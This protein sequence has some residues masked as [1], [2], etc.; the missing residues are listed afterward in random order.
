MIRAN[1][2]FH[3]SLLWAIMILILSSCTKEEVEIATGRGQEHQRLY[4]IS[5]G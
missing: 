2:F 3:Y 4:N 5:Y 1:H